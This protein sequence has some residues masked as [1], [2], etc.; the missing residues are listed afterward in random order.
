M[1]LLLGLGLSAAQA[2]VVTITGPKGPLAAELVAVEAA[3]HIA[4]IIPGSGP[5]D[6]D[7]NGRQVGLASDSYKLLAEGLARAGVA[8]LRIDKRGFFGSAA[9]IADPNDVTIATYAADARNWVLKAREIAPCVWLAGHS[10]GGLV[11]LVAARDAPKGLCGVILL[12]TGGRPVGQI[13]L[14]QLRANPANVDLMP[15]LEEIIA[16]LERGQTRPM[17]D[18]SPVLRGFFSPG[19][20]RYMMDLFSYD[21][22][23]VA[24]GWTGPALVVQGG[25]DAQITALDADLLAAALQQPE[26]HMIDDMTH[27][28]KADVPAAPFATYTDPTLPLHP[29]LVQILSEFMMARPLQ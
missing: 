13:M 10:E 23:D 3:Q 1:G 16:D 5:I 26:Q 28:L 25:K 2:D 20:Q 29:E 22:V 24:I 6:R 9:A 15:E 4:V 27:M 14:E 7:G 11:T 21:P 8:S 18:I 17:A 12:A 19:L